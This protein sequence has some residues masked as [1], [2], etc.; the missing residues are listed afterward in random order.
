MSFYKVVGNTA[1]PQ[2]HTV[3]IGVHKVESPSPSYTLLAEDKD[4]Y[5]YPVDG[6]YWYDTVNEASIA[7][8]VTGA[9][10][11]DGAT[12]GESENG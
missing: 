1:D 6:W 3:Y 9:L 4:T 7:F 8:G 12:Y 5:T 10:G 11:L 2:D